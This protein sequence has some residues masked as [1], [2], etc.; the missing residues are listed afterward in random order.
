MGPSGPGP[1]LPGGQRL[2]RQGLAACGDAEP[3]LGAA[4]G[5]AGGR[6]QVDGAGPPDQLAD[7][8]HMLF[9]DC[10]DH[11]TLDKEHGR[12]DRRRY[13]VKA[14]SDLGWDGNADPYGRWQ[15]IRI[16]RERQVVK[17]G[18]TSTEVRYALT[19]LTAD[20]ATPTQLAALVRHHWHIERRLHSVRDFTYDE[21]RC[22]VWLR[23]LP[24]NL[25]CLNDAAISIIRCQPGFLW[26]P[27]ANRYYAARPQEAL[28]LLLAPPRS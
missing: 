7:L 15:A 8:Q 23:D 6:A 10:P 14:L 27:E 21:D 16:K 18:E 25:A 17:T 19:S 20:Q 5:L 26:I 28:D 1:S 13:W 4:G 12:I 2:V 11:E 24:R 3:G 9:E 22:R